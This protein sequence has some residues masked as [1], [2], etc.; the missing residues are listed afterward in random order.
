MGSSM[1]IDIPRHSWISM[2]A[3]HE[4][5]W[6]NRGAHCADFAGSLGGPGIYWVRH[7]GIIRG[8]FGR[9]FGMGGVSTHAH[10]ALLALGPLHVE[11]TSQHANR[12]I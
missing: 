4:C 7:L 5:A 8:P 10:G 11:T 1:S 9:L 6:M 2:D 3:G 12:A